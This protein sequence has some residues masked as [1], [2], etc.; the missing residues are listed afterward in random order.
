[1]IL[2]LHPA[3]Q[4]Q[5][6]DAATHRQQSIIITGPEGIGLVRA[7][8]YFASKLNSKVRY[9]RPVDRKTEKVDEEKGI[10]SIESIRELYENTRSK[11][12]KPQ[13]I[14]I[15]HAERI[16]ERAQGAFLKLLEEP[17]ENLY[18]ILLT[19]SVSLLLPTIRSRASLLQLHAVS[20]EQ[21]ED[22]LNFYRVIDSAKRAK[23]LFI[24]NGLPEKLERLAT[25][26]SYYET[27]SAGM[28]DAKCLLQG[29]LYD[30]LVLINRYKDDRSAA[31]ALIDKTIAIVRQTVSS[32]PSEQL[33]TKLDRLLDAKS[34]LAANSSV[35]LTL[36][37]FVVY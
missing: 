8:E 2:P 15:T 10:I 22:I 32:Q 26:E 11:T 14:A 28:S 34:T 1:M 36:S 23:I 17:H 37:R 5:L 35:R 30:K 16:S 29:D 6:E 21:S 12:P 33:V 4:K 19:H 27:E 13:V 24:A 7:A 31:T 9:V 3:S 18:F 25:E 20:S